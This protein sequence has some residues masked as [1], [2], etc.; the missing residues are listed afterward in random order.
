MVNNTNPLPQKTAAAASTAL[1]L[2]FVTYL[3][4][5]L[6]TGLGKPLDTLIGLAV[7]VLAIAVLTLL[8]WLILQALRVVRLKPNRYIATVLASSITFIGFLYG[9]EV[10]L[11]VA[12]PIGGV[13]V[14]AQIGLGAGIGLWL[15]GTARKALAFGWVGVGLVL[16]MII[17]VLLVSPG[18]DSHLLLLDLPPTETLDAADPAAPGPFKV[19]TLSYGSGT[20][21]HRPEF[22]ENVDLRTQPVDASPFVGLDE[23]GANVRETYWGFGLDQF[24]RNGRVWYPDEDG[25]FP[26]VLI[27]HGQDYMTEPADTGYAYLGELF[28]SHGLIAVS[29]DETFLNTYII[30]RVSQENDARGVL[31]LEHIRQWQMWN[32]AEG[33]PFYHKV[34]LDSIA[35]IGHSRGGEAAAI[36]AAFARLDAYPDDPTILFDYDFTI[37][38]VIGIA[39]SYGQY[40]PAGKDL[41]LEDVNYLLLQGSHDAD[42]FSNWGIRM[43]NR[44]GFSGHTPNIK[45]ALYVYRANHSQFN[46]AWGRRDGNI[47]VR[48]LLNQKALLEPEQQ[49]QV[50][51]VFT[52]AFL[53]V[54]LLDNPSYLSIFQDPC[55]ARDWLPDTL[56]AGRYSD[57]TFHPIAT[58]EEDNDPE[59]CSLAQCTLSGQDLDWEEGEVEFRYGGSQHNNAVSIAWEQ[60]NGGYIIDLPPDFACDNNLTS[61]TVLAFDL[62]DMA[63]HD[64]TRGLLDLT[65]ELI[66]STGATAQQSLSDYAAIWPPVPVQFTKWAPWEKEFGEPT[67]PIFQTIGIPLGRFGET[68]PARL[69]RIRFLFDHTPSGTVLLDEVGFRWG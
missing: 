22:G 32:Q 5:T 25:P 24:P 35:I 23:F 45:A 21:P 59:T 63:P 11:N 7:G 29:V 31:L 39:P 64:A 16:T 15:A 55:L 9:F 4:S 36:A 47:P 50:A 40:R 27:V 17:I 37:K 56:Y 46:T 26:L 43:Y 12:L 60:A 67:E 1:T 2:V 54:T 6:R 28:A 48:W 13:L 34:D 8:V 14:L 38:T 65:I 41:H 19:Q 57:S 10:P 51:Q 68:D 30:A 42:S 44:V 18:S 69:T 49:R 58:Y 33:N 3:G 52:M 66:D 20:D 62:A 53:E 61:S